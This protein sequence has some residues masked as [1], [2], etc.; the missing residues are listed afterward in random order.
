MATILQKVSQGCVR[1]TSRQ[2]TAV[3]GGKKWNVQRPKPRVW[4]AR[5]LESITRPI[6]V[7]DIVPIS[8][9]CEK[10][11]ITTQDTEVDEYEEFMYKQVKKMFDENTMILVCQ[12]LSMP[13]VDKRKAINTMKDNGMRLWFYNN[14]LI[15]RAITEYSQYKNMAP[16]IIGSNVY[17]VCPEPKVKEALKILKKI[18]DFIVLGGLVENSLYSKDG[19]T[20]YS[21]LPNIE[22]LRGELVSVLNMAA[23]GKTH[24]L[25]ESHQQ[26]LCRNLTQYVKQKTDGEDNS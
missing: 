14:R 22:Q 11:E 7:E 21:Q 8:Q 17:V 15:R 25:L 16:W 10:L 24:S 1:C 18:P 4:K 6:Y 19:L 2:W 5:V 3:R 9:S 12:M 23:G 13:T 20:H 26:T